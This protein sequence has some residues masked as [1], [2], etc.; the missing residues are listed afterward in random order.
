[1]SASI[2]YLLLLFTAMVAY[3][4]SKW[5]QACLRDRLAYGA[6]ILPMLYL[7][8]LYVTEMPWPNLDELVHFFFAEPAKRIVETVKLPS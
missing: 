2:V 4:F 3:D 5:K 6:L 7:G 1:M 8:I